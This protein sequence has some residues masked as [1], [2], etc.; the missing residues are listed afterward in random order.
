MASTILDTLNGLDST[1]IDEASNTVTYVG[2]APVGSATS[3][4]VWRI[5]KIT[6][7][8]TLTTVSWADGDPLADNVWDNRASLSYS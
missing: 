8:G 5:S 2:K 3:A 7:S 6:I 1:L 4:A